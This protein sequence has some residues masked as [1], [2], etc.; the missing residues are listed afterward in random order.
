M[1]FE[2]H[3]KDVLFTITPEW[4]KFEVCDELSIFRTYRI[5]SDLWNDWDMDRESG[6]L[7]YVLILLARS[8]T[9][10]AMIPK[11]YYSKPIT[12]NRFTSTM[13]AKARVLALDV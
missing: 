12:V 4:Q 3:N 13:F 7:L 9:N 6:S 2:A 10:E 1:V 11:Y 5:G 8:L